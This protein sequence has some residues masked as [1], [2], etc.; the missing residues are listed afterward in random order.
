VTYMRC[1]FDP[2]TNRR[3][4]GLASLRRSAF[5]AYATSDG[6]VGPPHSCGLAAEL[7]SVAGACTKPDARD[8]GDSSHLGIQALIDSIEHPHQQARGLNG[9]RGLVDIGV[10]NFAMSGGVTEDGVP[11]IPSQRSSSSTATR[12]TGLAP[13]LASWNRQP[14]VT[15]S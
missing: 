6:R 9:I 13:S 10:V 7:L 3:N 4:P 12:L 5:L 15:K 1:V 8:P 11:S 14:T 2:T